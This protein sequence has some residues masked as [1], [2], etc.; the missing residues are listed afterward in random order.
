MTIALGM[1]NM[2]SIFGHIQTMMQKI[3]YAKNMKIGM[4]KK[5]LKCT[6]RFLNHWGNPSSTAASSGG[7][8]YWYYD[9]GSYIIFRYGKVK[10][11]YDVN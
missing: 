5:Q 8:S 9:D 6:Y 10:G 3:L 4:T 7:W 1:R 11:W 2:V